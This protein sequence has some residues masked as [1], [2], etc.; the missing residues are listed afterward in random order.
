MSQDLGTPVGE[1]GPRHWKIAKAVGSWLVVDDPFPNHNP[2]PNLALFL[3]LVVAKAALL[4]LTRQR[5][6]DRP[7]GPKT[8]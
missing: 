7:A 3:A 8:K 4:V 1:D 2:A 5:K 6:I